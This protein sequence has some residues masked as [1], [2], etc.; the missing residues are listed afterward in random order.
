[1]HPLEANVKVTIKLTIGE[2]LLL[3]LA[4][5]KRG[6]SWLRLAGWHQKLN[7]SSVYQTLHRL[8]GLGLVSEVNGRFFITKAGSDKIK[9]LKQ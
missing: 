8:K 2:K 1:M 4:K 5:Y 9:G 6:A 7:Y 3:S